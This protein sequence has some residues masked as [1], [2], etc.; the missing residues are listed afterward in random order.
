M[1]TNEQSTD[2]KEFYEKFCKDVAEGKLVENPNNLYQHFI[3]ERYKIYYKEKLK[4][5][6]SN[7]VVLHI[8]EK[9]AKSY[10]KVYSNLALKELFDEDK[11]K[12][13][14]NE[15]AIKIDLALQEGFIRIIDG[16]VS[17]I[18]RTFAE[19]AAADLFF[20]AIEFQRGDMDKY[21]LAC[22]FL[23]KHIFKADSGVFCKFLDYRLAEASEI[24][25]LVLNN[26]VSK[27]HDLLSKESGSIID[28]VDLL[29]RSPLHLAVFYSC[30]D[31]CALLLEKG[32]KL[33]IRD[34]FDLTPLQY[35]EKKGNK[36]ILELFLN[37]P[38][39]DLVPNSDLSTANVKAGKQRENSV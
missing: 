12:P 13:F 21:K 5:D 22:D 4:A 38:R 23:H 18:H 25:T 29:G 7:I 33:D 35:A 26:D 6:T 2:Q 17:F 1:L 16:K 31:M 28:S 19:Y 11:I 24:H 20:R 32:A 3:E 34:N 15:D 14:I 8:I 9:E 27:V 10:A 36:E 37:N 39:R 30:K